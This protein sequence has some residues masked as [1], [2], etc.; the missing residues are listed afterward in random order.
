MNTQIKN[1]IRDYFNIKNISVARLKKDIMIPVC[2]MKS[3]LN[4]EKKLNKN[5]KDDF[6]QQENEI[7]NNYILN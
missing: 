3:Y 6:E 4:L 2:I 7:K 1:D 5:K